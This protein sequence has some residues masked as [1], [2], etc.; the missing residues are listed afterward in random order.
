MI[1][2]NCNNEF[3]NIDGLKFCAYCGWEIQVEIQEDIQ[4][5]VQENIQEHIELKDEHISDK[6]NNEESE[7]IVDADEKKK[8]HE[9]TQPMPVIT[10]EHIKKYNRQQFFENLKKIFA[11]KITFPNK[12]TFKVIIPI[13]VLLVVIA[14]G[15]FAYTLF[16]VKP[17]DEVRVKQD[18]MGKIITLPKGTRIKIS[19]DY[20]KKLSIN[21]RK[22]DKHK[23]EIKVSLTL[24]NGAIEANTLLSIVYE[25]QGKNQWRISDKIV[26]DKATSIKPVLGMNEK[27]FLEALKKLSI[28]I[29]DTE[30]VLGGEDVKNL[31]I[32]L[33]TPDLKNGKE[34]IKVLTSIDSGL[35]ATTGK[36]KCKLI[37]E[38]EAWGIASIEKDKTEAFT[39]GLSKTFSDEKAIEAIKKQG[40]EEIVSYSSFFGGKEYTVKDSFTK[41]IKIPG[42]RYDA[43]KGV[44]Y[45]NAERENIAGE[46]KSV[47]LTGYTFSISLDK[48]AL[49]DK[50]TTTVTSGTINNITSPLIIA[51]IANVEIES[52]NMLF[53]W[54]SNHKI[55]TEEAKTFKTDKIVSEKGFQNIKNVY[56]SITYIDG[57]KKKSGSVVASYF[58]VYDGTKGY[59]WKLDKIIGQDSSKAP[60]KKSKR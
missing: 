12:K 47:L 60:N 36:I 48:I 52:N 34:E 32:N 20:I 5:N 24:N 10:Q 23:E 6:I 15:V 22:T 54:T 14:G 28:S 53:W 7:I 44:L 35:M 13:I 49:I 4:E 2:K 59:N 1:C 45:V 57:K 41:N 17:V 16:N 19:K 40:L 29:G 18:L 58:L 42:K 56:G 25:Y 3:T 31:G 43:Q 33:R 50:S 8:K 39:L 27:K 46:V 21:T 38:N 37:F 11:N 26:L 30:V 55:T 9:N 51:T